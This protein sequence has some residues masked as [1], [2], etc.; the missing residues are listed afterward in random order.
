MVR[1]GV[2]TDTFEWKIGINNALDYMCNLFKDIQFYE[3]NMHQFIYECLDLIFVYYVF[4]YI[5]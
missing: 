2:A 5:F 4:R 3:D 1:S